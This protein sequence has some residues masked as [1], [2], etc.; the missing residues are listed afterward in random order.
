[1]NLEFNVLSQT[2]LSNINGGGLA[3]AIATGMCAV[4][5][6]ALTIVFPPAGLL[7]T[8]AIVVGEL[9]VGGTGTYLAAQL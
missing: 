6:I 7:L 5:S 4:G 9:I 8:G 2:E 3:A 1:M